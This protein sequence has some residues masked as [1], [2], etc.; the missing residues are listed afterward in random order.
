[1]KSKKKVFVVDR[2]KTSSHYGRFLNNFETETDMSK[3]D[4]VIFTGGEDV[5]PSFYNQE[6]ITG[7]HFSDSR[8][9]Y[10]LGMYQKALSLKKPMLGICRGS[11]FLTVMNGGSLIQDV[12]NHGRPHEVEFMYDPFALVEVLTTEVTSTH[13]Q[14]MAPFLSLEE[15][16]Y[17]I[18]AWSKTPLATKYRIWKEGEET[19]INLKDYTKSF[20]ELLKKD[21]AIEP[22]MVYYYDTNC[23]CMQFHPEYLEFSKMTSN[24]GKSSLEVIEEFIHVYL[25][26]TVKK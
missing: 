15:S 8:D 12:N 4:L 26:E 22:E 16:S 24:N 2:N 9:Y 1:M 18:L 11:Q 6:K 25:F 7:T 21:H 19:E 14:M 5:N 13:H 10:E 3:A 23:L 20:S 17:D